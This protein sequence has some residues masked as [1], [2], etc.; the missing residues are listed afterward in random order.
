MALNPSS[1]VTGSAITGFTA[2]TYTIVSDQAPDTFSKQ[3]LVSALG[4]TQTGVTPQDSVANPFTITARRPKQLAIGPMSTL[5]G[6]LIGRAKRN[7]HSYILRKGGL[8]NTG[9]TQRDTLVGRLELN[10]PGGMEGAAAAEIKGAISAYF[11][12]LHA[13]AD[14][15][16]SA[17]ILGSI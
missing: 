13:N 11:G 5:N 3:W 8:V 1:P 14:A 9:S 7:K 10:V 16:A 17:I 15:I 6:Q 2:P 12:F 4:G